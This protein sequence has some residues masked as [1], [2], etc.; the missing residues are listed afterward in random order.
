MITDSSG[1]D[2]H[3]IA[4]T[5]FALMYATPR[6]PSRTKAAVDFFRWALQHGQN[7][8]GELGFVALPPNVVS[9]IEAYW[10]ARFTDAL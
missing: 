5:S 6:L 1:E 10:R 9:L 7:Q 3:P 2:A 4:A 8:A